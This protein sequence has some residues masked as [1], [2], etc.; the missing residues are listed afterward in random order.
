MPVDKFGHTDSGNMQRVVAGGVTLTQA[1]NTFVRRDGTNAFVGNLDLGGK[2]IEGLSTTYTPS[3]DNLLTNKKYVDLRVA[4][5]A[6]R[7]YVPGMKVYPGNLVRNT[8]SGIIYRFE[9]TAGPITTVPALSPN[10]RP[11]TGA[12]ICALRE[13]SEDQRIIAD[14]EIIS[15][16]YN[17]LTTI[18]INTDSAYTT[19]NGLITIP[20]TGV[21]RLGGFVNI[22]Y[23]VSP[24]PR[25]TLL[26][27]TYTLNGDNPN[28]LMAY[29]VEKETGGALQFINI[30][31][32]C[33]T[34]SLVAGSQLGI[35]I[36]TTLSCVIRKYSMG[37]KGC[38]LQVEFLY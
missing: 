26:R 29:G 15:V 27:A 10:W 22:L 23:S 13:S 5:N 19:A 24:A 14:N 37:Y 33:P 38:G 21:Y 32:P 25:G 7:D 12:A 2:T 34:V 6:I 36:T 30:T 11:T 18:A 20:R 17:K 28:E 31:L 16:M 8:T 35:L 4:S 3:E 1:N 9:G